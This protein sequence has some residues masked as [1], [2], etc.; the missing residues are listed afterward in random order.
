M[1]E[2]QQTQLCPPVVDLSKEWG[3]HGESLLSTVY[4]SFILFYLL[5][6]FASGSGSFL[7]LL[8]ILNLLNLLV[9]IFILVILHSKE[10][11]RNLCR[12]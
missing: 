7:C 8:D 5:L 4:P 6:S 11:G 3:K 2:A 10:P 9:L 12:R 1:P